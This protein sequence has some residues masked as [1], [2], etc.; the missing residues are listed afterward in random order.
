MPVRQVAPIVIALAQAPGQAPRLTV[1]LEPEELGRVEI[2]IERG[3][4]GEAATVQVMAER[5]ETLALL[6]RDQRELDRALQG[7][8]VAMAEGSLRFSLG[9]QDRPGGQA[10]GQAQGQQGG[11]GGARRDQAPRDPL[12][13]S[14]PAT[15][16]LSLL[17]I[18]V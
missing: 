11:G 8:G 6:A 3:A 4:E 9:G 13:Q 15:T 1:A 10:Q 7:A 14:R 12:A 17:D 16:S 18:A 2:R 5:P